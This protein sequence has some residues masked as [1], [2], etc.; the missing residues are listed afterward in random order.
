[1][2]IKSEIISNWVLG[3]DIYKD[4]NDCQMCYAPKYR[5]LEGFEYNLKCQ[6]VNRVISNCRY[7]DNN[8]NCI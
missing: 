1:L 3:C 2:E 8:Q 5:Y 6:S 4:E 7:Y